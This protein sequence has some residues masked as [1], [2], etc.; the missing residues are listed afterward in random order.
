[1]ISTLTHHSALVK[2][3]E[4]INSAALLKDHRV[5]RILSDG[6]ILSIFN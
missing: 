2:V 6:K 1:M 5:T 4:A 3:P